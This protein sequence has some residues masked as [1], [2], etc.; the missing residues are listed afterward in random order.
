MYK[1]D[2]HCMCNSENGTDVFL[3][4]DGEG[5]VGFVIVPAV[6]EGC[7][8]DLEEGDKGIA[9]RSYTHVPAVAH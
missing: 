9:G 5:V 4:V 8:A 2:Y 7:S 1:D 6:F 3:E